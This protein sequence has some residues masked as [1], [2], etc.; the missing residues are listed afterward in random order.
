MKKLFLFTITFLVC[1]FNY[2]QKKE[3]KSVDKLIKSGNFIEAK[4]SLELVRDLI[5][6]SDEKTKAKFY[7]LKGLSNYQNG[8]ASFENKLL[9]IKSFN[10]AKEIEENTSKLYTTKIE[11]ILTNLL[12][13]FVNDSKTALENK[14]YEQSY[15]NYEAAYRVSAKDTL[16]LRNA[17]LVAN[18]GKF[19][20]VALQYYLELVDLGFTGLSMLYKAVEI[21]SGIEQNFQDKK[22]RDIAVDYI[23]T[24]INPTDELSESVEASIL[25]TIAAIYKDK[26]E[27]DNALSYLNKAKVISPEDINIILLESIIRYDMG[28]EKS[29]LKLIEKALSIDPNNV[30][31]IVNQG[32][33]TKSQGNNTDALNYFLKAIEIDPNS[34]RANLMAA[35]TILEEEEEIN[36]KM[37]KL[38]EVM[39]TDK[40]FKMY[41]SFKDKKKKL[42]RKSIPFLEKVFEIDPNDIDSVKTLKNIYQYLDD[43][44]NVEK[45][46]SVVTQLENK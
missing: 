21:E 37:N 11:D 22:Q 29:Y 42:Y 28:D 45:Y 17:A 31:L 19:Y 4:A 27:L 12:N 36:E 35:V 34:R 32:I 8:D 38:A 15:R 39:R 10:T 41:D 16:Y 2:A 18:E 6:T 14:N 26:G 40:D 9:S 5:T 20:D 30:E 23:K 1:Q 3:L 13:S 7:Y 33:V 25:R 24:H 46:E 44:E 43:S